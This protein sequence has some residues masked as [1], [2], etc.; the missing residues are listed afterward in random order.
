[1]APGAVSSKFQTWSLDSRHALYPPLYMHVRV[2]TRC[3]HVPTVATRAY[4]RADPLVRSSF[5]RPRGREREMI[6]RS[7]QEARSYFTTTV[8]RQIIQWPLDVSVCER[9]I[10]VGYFG[11]K[12]RNW[13][14]GWWC[15][16]ERKIERE[17]ERGRG[18]GV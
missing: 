1:M 2:Y 12:T 3:A 17:R 18:A 8:P 16:L 10:R 4:H 13:R 7:W 14:A 15:G 6:D 11:D 9:C 5:P